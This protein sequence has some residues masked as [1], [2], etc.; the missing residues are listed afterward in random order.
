M[1][2][3]CPIRPPVWLA[4]GILALPG[5]RIRIVRRVWRASTILAQCGVPAYV[6]SIILPLGVLLVAASAARADDTFR[7]ANYANNQMANE[8]RQLSQPTPTPTPQPLPP[9]A[10][11]PANSLAVVIQGQN[12][13]AY[14]PEGSWTGTAPGVLVVPLEPPG[15]GSPTLIATQNSVNSCASNSVTGETI[16]T[17]NN[18]DVY[19]INGVTL[20]STLTSAGTGILTPFSGGTCTNCQVAMDPLSDA[21]VIGLALG[22]GV[23]G[24]QFLHL[25]SASSTFDPPI[26]VA[27]SSGLSLQISD[28]FVVDPIRHLILAPVEGSSLTTPPANYRILRTAPST[29]LFD[30]ARASTTFTGMDFLPN[31][32]AEDCTT[33]IAL[34]DFE[35]TGN[36]FI[37]DLSQ[38]MFKAGSPQGTWTAPFRMQALNEFVKS[39][40]FPFG[41]CGMAV[42]PGTH[43]A[44]V[45]SKGDYVKG[46]PGGNGFGV[47]R[48]PATSGVGIPSILD[49]V[50]A[51]MPDLPDDSDWSTGDD[52]HTVTAYV[53][54]NNG[55]AYAVIGNQT[56]TWLGVV[57]LEALLNPALRSYRGSHVVPYSVDLQAGPTPIVSYY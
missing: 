19:V 24:F 4:V 45:T 51:Y 46:Y 27:D 28:G 26:R 47:I 2:I 43:L 15:S 52:P 20:T 41:V 21:A 50:E 16:C 31:S 35:D 34:A 6:A 22:G 54:P 44:V 25:G 42:V 57:D 40:P 29:Q 56:H 11:L 23:G 7:G 5:R 30:F 36:F 53:S 17:A 33:G 12:V 37:A 49:W 39:Y 18:A 13:T 14:V 1:P 48:L 3:G 38:A 8:T 55:K 9:G 32:A 10:C